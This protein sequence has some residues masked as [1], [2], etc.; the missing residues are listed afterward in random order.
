MG[1]RE[2]YLITERPLKAILAF[3]FPMMLGNLFQQFYTMADSVI[4]GRFLGED[5]LAAVGASYALTAVFIAIAIGG[6]AGATVITSREFGAKAFRKMKE[7]I[8]TALIAFLLLSLLL[9]VMGFALSPSILAVLN[10]PENIMGDACSYLRIYFLGLPFL[11]M[12]NILSSV[13]NSLGRSRIPL[14]LLVFSS[15]LN[16]AL[17]IV[18]VAYMGMGVAGAAWATLLAQAISAIISSIMLMRILSRMDG[19]AMKLF[20]R[21]ISTQMARI[22]LPSILQQSTISIGMMLVQSVVNAFGSEV[23]AGYSASIRIDNIVTVPFSAIGNA[24]SPYTA[25][26]IGAGRTDRIRKIPPSTQRKVERIRRMSSSSLAP[27]FWANR[28]DRPRVKPVMAST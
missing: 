7:S 20:S 4:V 12:Y 25:Q 22:A 28:M 19:K 27:N 18:A 23:L 17:D 15:L 1:R 8:S 24:M 3:S 9:G 11:F 14:C 2:D 16:I 13:F 5:A 26:N 6:G 21:D 10:T